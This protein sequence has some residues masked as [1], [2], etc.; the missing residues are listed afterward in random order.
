MVSDI[1]SRRG[2]VGDKQRG[3]LI[4]LTAVLVAVTVLASVI[5][6]NVIHVPAD[7]KTEALTEEPDRIQRIDA[8]LRDDLD[9]IFLQVTA[10]TDDNLSGHRLP[11]V[12]NTGAFRAAVNDSTAIRR[13]MTGDRSGSLLSVAYDPDRTRMGTAVFQTADSAFTSAQGDRDW[14]LLED[15]SLLSLEMTVT[16]RSP[17]NGTLNVTGDS[18]GTWELDISENNVYTTDAGP[19]CNDSAIPDFESATIHVAVRNG[20]GRVQA[21]TDNG[22][23]RCG[24]FT[25]AAGLDTPWNVSIHDG[26]A[27]EGTY[28]ITGQG[29]PTANSSQYL[30]GNDQPWHEHNVIVNPAF[31]VTYVSDGVTYRST[32]RLNNRTGR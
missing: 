9:S 28:G 10:P 27:L 4:L 11:F 16:G 6:L 25:V 3:Q 18:G 5:L 22:T 14:R 23:L 2:P 32:F 1:R 15:A 12:W 31:N 13:N 30:S 19:L 29:D 7:I 17:T 20:D 21:R 26:D 24:G 8:S